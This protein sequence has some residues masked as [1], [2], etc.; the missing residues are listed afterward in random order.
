MTSSAQPL[1]SVLTAVYNG[2]AYLAECIESVLAQTYTNWEYII[3]DNCSN[4]G[5]PEIVR[6]YA[7]RHSRIRVFRNDKF[8]P[9]MENHNI[10]L[11][12][13]SP[14]SKS[15]TIWRVN[16]KSYETRARV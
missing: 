12:R 11:T 9:V 3:N 5:T 14:Q 13:I 2:E 8:V 16:T 7:G 10:A 6:Q 1:V 4:D 15:R